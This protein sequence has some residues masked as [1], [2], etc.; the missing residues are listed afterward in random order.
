APLNAGVRHLRTLTCGGLAA[1][2]LERLLLLRHRLPRSERATG[3]CCGWLK[4]RRWGAAALPSTRCLTSDCSGARAAQFLWLLLRPLARPL[5]R[6]VR[7]LRG[8]R[9]RIPRSL[10]V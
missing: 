4:A 5:N 10:I 9:S 8:P 2:A 1:A 6:R 7:R 3:I